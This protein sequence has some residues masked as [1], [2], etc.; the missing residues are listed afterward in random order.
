MAR[1]EPPVR[2]PKS[3]TVRLTCAQYDT[4]RRLGGVFGAGD[5]VRDALEA[6]L[7][8]HGVPLVTDD[9]MAAMASHPPPD[10]FADVLPPELLEDR[11]MWPRCRL[12]LAPYAP[13]EQRAGYDQCERHGLVDATLRPRS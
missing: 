13:S 7:G 4:L 12:C 3:I 5:L 11:S 1:A 10:P 8:A 6:Y 9:A 2:F